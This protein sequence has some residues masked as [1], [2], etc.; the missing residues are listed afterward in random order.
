[1]THG[2][3]VIAQPVVPDALDRVRELAGPRPVEVIE[4][5]A[6]SADLPG[7]LLN[8]AQILFADQP[9]HNIAAARQLR[10]MQLGS[11]GY[12]QL[13]GCRLPEEAVVTNASGVQDVPIAEW[14]VLMMLL[15]SRDAVG[16]LTAQREHR[17]DRNPVF[18]G[19]LAGKRVGIW[20]YGNIGRELARACRALGLEVFVLSRSG[21]QDRGLRY[22]GREGAG[23]VAPDALFHA[24]EEA[25]F[26]AELDF[27]VLTLPLTRSTRGLVDA[28]I[29]RGLPPRAFLLNPAR[30]GIVDEPALLDAL[31]SG[32]IAGAALD[33]HYRQPMPPD[34]PFWDLPNTVVTAHISGSNYSPHFRTRIWDLFCANLD[35]WT[36]G[37]ELLNVIDRADLGLATD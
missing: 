29:L 25:E 32:T 3:I 13:D 9:P 17:W 14:C 21:A 11:H 5:Y 4:P 19:E 20:G 24:G 22:H 27:L 23:S 36:R 2:R 16:M 30:A 33:D 10:W 1:M 31:R 15:L 34:D 37:E 18:Q 35:R 8:D 7:S 6:P 12:G 28:D 26:L